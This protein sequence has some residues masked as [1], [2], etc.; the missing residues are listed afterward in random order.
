MKKTVYIEV[1]TTDPAFNLALEEYVFDNMSREKEYFLT[2]RN[3]NAIIVGRQ[4]KSM[5]NLSKKRTFR[6]CGA[7]PA[8]VRCTTIWAI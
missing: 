2:W 7:W 1:G 6:W 4:R 8:A 3:D 5:R